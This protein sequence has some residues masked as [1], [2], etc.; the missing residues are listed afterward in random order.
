MATE[1]VVRR[2]LMDEA[3]SPRQP[4]PSIERTMQPG[5]RLSNPLNHLDMRADPDAQA[6]VSDFLDFT[7]YL[8]ADITR[9]LTLIGN[10]SET[11]VNSSSKL[12]DLSTTWGNLPSIPSGDKT[13]AVRLREEIADDLQHALNSR[14]YSLAEAQRMTENVLR[15]YARAKTILGKLSTMRENYSAAE[16]QKSPV[17]TKS[18]QMSRASKITTQN[19]G[20]K[21]RRPRVP[22][23]TVPGEVLAP[24]DLNYDVYTTGSDSSSGEEEEETESVTPAPHA[25][26]KLAKGASKTPKP[27]RPPRPAG[28]VATPGTPGAVLLSTSAAM[29]QLAP[30]PVNAVV[31]GPDAPWGQLTPYEL[32][33]LRKRMKKNA[34]WTPSDTMV[35]RELN[36]LGRGM[37][38]FRAA[39]QKAEEEGEVFEGK[40]PTPDVDPDTGQTRMPAGALTLEALA[41]DEK[42]LSNRGMKLNEAKKLK[43]EMLAKMA[44]EEAEESARRFDAIARTLMSD[45]NQANAQ[46]QSKAATKAKGQRKRKRDSAPEAEIEKPE[47]VEGQ[48]QQPQRPQLKRTKTETPVPPPLLTPGGSQLPHETPTQPPQRTSNAGMLH[49]TTPIPLPIH[50]QEQSITAKSATPA[51][52]ATSP[53]SSYAGPTSVPTLAP[54]KL[55]AAETPI[56][57]PVISP[58]KSMTPILPPTRETRKTQAAR[59]QEQQQQLDARVAQV[60]GDISRSTSPAAT[61]KPD[62]DAASAV[63][64]TPATNSTVPRRPV[65]RGKAASQEPQSSLAADRPRRASTARNTPAPDR[66]DPQQQQQQQ[67]PQ[68]QQHPQRTTPTPAPSTGTGTGTG[69]FPGPGSFTGTSAATAATLAAGGARP[70]ANKRTKGRPRVIFSGQIRG[71]KSAWAMARGAPAR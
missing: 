16:E 31:G 32:A 52:S 47:T 3:I 33:R 49:S 43:R 1:D 13:G 61:P 10:L 64:P 29:A 58:K 26:I 25:R 36:G 37:D 67:Q 5:S 12:N 7:E 55:P 63:T 14:V 41:S 51:V 59:A 56:P 24:Y 4:A 68:P 48:P 69:T 60:I 62:P 21:V 50:S 57:P 46:D 23:I 54:V 6:T 17:M 44:A 38:A 66:T 35:A 65:S 30:P 71:V 39:K 70:A 28:S 20:Q 18:P 42:N 45:P 27:G 11:Y 22:R 19:D 34:A 53:A 2:D 8:P 15:H 9:S 40:M